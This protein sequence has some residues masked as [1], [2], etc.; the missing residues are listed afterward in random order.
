MTR[1]EVFQFGLLGGAA[2][3]LSGCSELSRRVSPEVAPARVPRGKVTEAHRLTN[4]LGFGPNGV[5]LA[6]IESLG[7]SGYVA[8]CLAA[9]QG[10]DPRLQFQMRRL[11]TLAMEAGDARN[12]PEEHV[13]QQLQQAAI[14]RAVYGSNPLQ[15][16]MAEFW[17]DHFNIYGRKGL[18]AYRLSRDVETVVRKH[19][20]GK[21]PDMLTASAKSP[22]MLL[23]LDN[24][25]NVDG[26][27]N[28]NY[29]R[30]IME[31]HTMGVDGGYTQQD[32]MEVARCFTGWKVE[33][34]PIRRGQFQF[35][36]SRHDDGEKIVLGERIPAG[37]GISDGYRVMEILC[38]HPATHRHISGKLVKR[39][40]G[41]EDGKWTRI[42]AARWKDSNGD[43]RHVLEPL[44]AGEDLVQSEPIY[45]RPFDFMVSA[46]RATG[47]QSD[48][49]TA[50]QTHLASMGQPVYQWPMPDGYPHKSEAWTG[51]TLAR[52]NF[53][54]DLTLDRID[55]TRIINRALDPVSTLYLRAREDRDFPIYDLPSQTEQLAAALMAPEF[56]WR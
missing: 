3:V 54:L 20:L 8:R 15:E 14:L 42:L 44:L 37:G 12:W 36:E 17:S 47:A 33:M 56:Q 1:R 4:R 5:E 22:A 34:G 51:T 9:D 53:A 19:A 16:R 30:E 24:H 21:F 31:L 45:K 43:I 41:R 10:E 48:G 49:G 18:A 23:Y 2:A 28:E 27:P 39:F 35:D 7:R 40:L 26:V 32:V 11:E 46:L 29:A 52:W 50:L 6:A 25:F 13:L 55:G 38:A